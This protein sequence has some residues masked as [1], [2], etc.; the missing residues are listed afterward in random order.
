[1]II[2]C[3]TYE[4]HPLHSGIR[5]TT[6]LFNERVSNTQ[7]WWSTCLAGSGVHPQVLVVLGESAVCWGGGGGGKETDEQIISINIV[8][9]LAMILVHG[10]EKVSRRCW[11]TAKP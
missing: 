10:S 9:W 3:S 11:H 8:H 5:I 1:M 7:P 2:K 4:K 6:V